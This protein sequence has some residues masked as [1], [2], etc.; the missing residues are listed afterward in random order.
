MSLGK[1]W[2][3]QTIESY[4]ICVIVENTWNLDIYAKV[5]KS[6]ALKSMLEVGQDSRDR[7]VMPGC[8]QTVLG[9]NLR[10]TWGGEPK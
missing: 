10:Y 3:V 4:I 9:T 6:V 8:G 7:M 2:D 1:A 5:K